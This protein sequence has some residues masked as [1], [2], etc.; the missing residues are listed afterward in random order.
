MTTP[1]PEVLGA[2]GGGVLYDPHE[3]AAL[4]GALGELLANPQR[5]ADLGRRGREG[6]LR[7]FS[8]QRVAQRLE[9]VY[10]SVAGPGG[11]GV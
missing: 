9:A 11:G 7:E 6:V 3:T 2:T 1:F 4:A 10:R 8:A 5:R